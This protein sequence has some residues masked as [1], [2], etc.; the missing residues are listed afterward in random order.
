MT[1]LTGKAAYDPYCELDYAFGR[2]G[3]KYKGRLIWYLKDGVLRY[4]ELRRKIKG[5][6]PKMLTQV[7]RELEDDELIVRT[8]Y[9]EVP[10]RVEYQL[11]ESA[12]QLLPFLDLLSTWG[13]EQMKQNNIPFISEDN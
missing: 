6:M 5:I 13:N 1:K 11:T 4:G 10:P 3:G 12:R 9:H 7:L 2:I 8:V